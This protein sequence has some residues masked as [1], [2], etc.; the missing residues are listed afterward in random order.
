V[1]D[2]IRHRR[3]KRDG[4]KLALVIA[5]GG[6][7]TARV[8]AGVSRRLGC[9]DIPASHP[10]RRTLLPL[11]ERNIAVNRVYSLKNQATLSE[12]VVRSQKL[13]ITKRHSSLALPTFSSDSCP[14]SSKQIC[15]ANFNV[16]PGAPNIPSTSL[17]GDTEDITFRRTRSQRSSPTVSPNGPMQRSGVGN[18]VRIRAGMSRN[19]QRV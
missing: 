6:Q 8:A 14:T 2:S 7:E 18:D 3:L 12:F 13:E 16:S 5:Q 15:Q 9:A 1:H 17:R 4:S 10:K 19:G 11:R